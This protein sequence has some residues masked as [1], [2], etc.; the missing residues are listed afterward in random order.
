MNGKKE[1]IINRNRTLL[2]A[3][4]HFLLGGFAGAVAVSV[5]H[6]LYCASLIAIYVFLHKE[7]SRSTFGTNPPRVANAIVQTNVDNDNKNN[8]SRTR[9]L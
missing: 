6:V 1:N 7:N 4:K 9:F 3:F 8:N 2:E 5:H